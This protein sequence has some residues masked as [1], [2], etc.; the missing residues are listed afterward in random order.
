M[1][2]TE[3]REKIFDDVIMLVL[4]TEE[5]ATNQEIK[6]CRQSLEAG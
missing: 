2:D 5:E 6:K 1:I 4:K 3:V